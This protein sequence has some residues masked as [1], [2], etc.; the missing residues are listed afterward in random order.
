ML[1]KKFS[2][3]A[4]ILCGFSTICCWIQKPFKFTPPESSYQAATY[5]L[6]VN[7]QT[8]T[9]NG[10][11]ITPDYFGS[12]RLSPIIGRNFI[13]EEYGSGQGQVAIINQELWKRK[14]NQDPGVIGQDI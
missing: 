5:E 2:A 12:S 13:P 9:I 1:T 11:A 14:F 4:L 3:I 8:I 7:G 6:S 10:A